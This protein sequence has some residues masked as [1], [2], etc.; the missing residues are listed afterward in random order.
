MQI[1]LTL[2]E[3][4]VTVLVVVV[5]ESPRVV[6]SSVVVSGVCVVVSAITYIFIS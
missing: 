4:T 2:P 3:M 6:T 1:T 5:P